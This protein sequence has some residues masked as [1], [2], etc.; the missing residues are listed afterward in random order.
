MVLFDGVCNLCVGLV[1]FL[2]QRDDRRRFRFASLQSDPAAEL[3]AEADIDRNLS[4]VVVLEGDQ[5][6]TQ[7]DAAIRIGRHLGGI[8]RLATIFRVIPTGIR[9]RLYRAVAE[10]RYRWFGQREECLVPTEDIEAR[11]LE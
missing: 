9:N 10:R 11:F 2:I 7:S 8:Y 5:V 3:L 1:Q 4:T 6:Y